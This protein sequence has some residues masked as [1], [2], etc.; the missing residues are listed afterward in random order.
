MRLEATFHFSYGNRPLATA[1]RND[2]QIMKILEKPTIAAERQ[3][4]AGLLPLVIHNVVL[5]AFGHPR[6]CCGDSQEARVD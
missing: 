2:S 6:R 5:S 3:A 4:E 1:L